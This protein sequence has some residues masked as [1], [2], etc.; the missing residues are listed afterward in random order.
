MPKKGC[1]MKG[2]CVTNW[3][4]MS[5]CYTEYIL[6]TFESRLRRQLTISWCAKKARTFAMAR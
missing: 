2:L 6:D 1:L 3:E 4:R 5:A